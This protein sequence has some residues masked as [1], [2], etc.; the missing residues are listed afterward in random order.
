MPAMARRNQWSKGQK[1]VMRRVGT[2][3]Q[4]H[5]G[6]YLSQCCPKY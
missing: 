6:V 3:E 5:W 1:K 2:E 4:E